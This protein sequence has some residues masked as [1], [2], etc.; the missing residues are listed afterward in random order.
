MVCDLCQIQDMD[1][2]ESTDAM[3][4]LLD[5]ICETHHFSVLHKMVHKF[6]PQGLTILYMLS[7]SHIS[8]H[9]FPERNYLA[10][11]IYTCREYPDNSIYLAIYKDLIR[12]FDCDMKLS[13]Y[14]IFHRGVTKP[15]STIEYI[16]L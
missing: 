2:L 7:E 8:I 1:R 16:H 4:F 14:R 15:E 13:T 10:F 3:E 6:D 9:T 5:R 11:D 12:W